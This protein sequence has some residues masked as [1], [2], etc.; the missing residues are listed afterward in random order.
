VCSSD[1]YERGYLTAPDIFKFGVWMTIAAILVV[2]LVALPYW[3]A[4]GVALRVQ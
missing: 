2:L 1:L 3:A 4:V